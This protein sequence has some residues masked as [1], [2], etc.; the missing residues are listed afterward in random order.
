MY[1]NFYIIKIDYI[2]T[3]IYIHTQWKSNF[4]SA[5]IDLRFHQKK[6]GQK[7]FYLQLIINTLYAYMY[8]SMYIY[9]N[10]CNITTYFCEILHRYFFLVLL[11]AIHCYNLD[12][13]AFSAELRMQETAF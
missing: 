6:R 1:Y 8:V 2:Y 10:K 9:I 11:F 5:T 7:R 12:I 13:I 4:F 3:Y